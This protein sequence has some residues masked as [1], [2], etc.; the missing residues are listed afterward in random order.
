MSADT[1]FLNV[2]RIT[3]NPVQ[4]FLCVGSSSTRFFTQR[5][6]I[7]S[8]DGSEHSLTLF[9]PAGQPALALG[10]LVTLEQVSA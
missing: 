10:E 2:E 9:L 8:R 6:V 7:H 3:V 4:T 1:T 5:V